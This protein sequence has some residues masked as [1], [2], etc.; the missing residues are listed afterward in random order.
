METGGQWIMKK[1][2]ILEQMPCDALQAQVDTSC[3]PEGLPYAGLISSFTTLQN[4]LVICDTG[5][6]FLFCF[7]DDYHLPFYLSHHVGGVQF[8]FHF[9]FPKL[10]RGSWK[11]IGNQVS[12]QT[13][14]FQILGSLVYLIGWLH[15]WREF[16]QCKYAFLNLNCWTYLRVQPGIQRTS[17]GCV[18]DSDIFSLIPH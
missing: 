11:L 7:W 17:L 18:V 16:I 6:F 5:I 4:Q 2:S 12:F 15:H 1:I 10:D 9:V 14:S 13:S 3:T 8:S